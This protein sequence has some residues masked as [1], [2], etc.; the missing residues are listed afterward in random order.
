MVGWYAAFTN[1]SSSPIG[2]EKSSS[3]LNSPS[4]SFWNKTHVVHTMIFAQATPLQNRN[5]KT[6]QS[7]RFLSWSPNE[8]GNEAISN[9]ASPLKDGNSC[10]NSRIWKECIKV[11]ET[12]Q[13]PLSPSLDESYENPSPIDD[14]IDHIH[15]CGRWNRRNGMK[16]K[17]LSISF[18][19][20]RE[21]VVDFER[22][23]C[24]ITTEISG[25]Q[26]IR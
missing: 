5:S 26:W 14:L 1:K 9:G 16:G 12:K 6:D 4:C 8:H 15:C 2:N 13:I 7:T 11:P 21:A 22:Q 25:E 17:Q 3:I 19:R 24:W 10:Y 23:E 20:E 18:E